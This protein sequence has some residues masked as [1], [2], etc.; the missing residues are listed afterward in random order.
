MLRAE[1]LMKFN[2]EMPHRK[3]LITYPEALIEKVIN[4]DTFSKNTI[5][6]KQNQ[7]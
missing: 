5:F 4:R 3:V 7:N 2:V 6:I 1:A